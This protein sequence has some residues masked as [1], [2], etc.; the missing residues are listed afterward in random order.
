MSHKD[1]FVTDSSNKVDSNQKKNTGQLTDES[2]YYQEA[3]LS[4]K[5]EF[6]KGMPLSFSFISNKIFTIPFTF[7]GYLTF[8]WKKNI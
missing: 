7:K 8:I 5:I 3:S 2:N 1:S 4:R 6:E